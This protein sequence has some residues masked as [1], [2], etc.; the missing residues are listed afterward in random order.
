MGNVEWQGASTWGE[1]EKLGSVLRWIAP[2]V[3]GTHCLPR[4]VDID[5]A[6]VLKHTEGDKERA[7]AFVERGQPGF[8]GE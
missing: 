7:R 5:N 2:G 8:R 4:L 6:L 3:G 1:M